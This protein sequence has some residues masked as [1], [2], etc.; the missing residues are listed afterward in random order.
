MMAVNSLHPTTTL[1]V[2][3]KIL[4]IL[5]LAPPVHGASMANG[6]LIKSPLINNHFELEIVNL[7]FASSVQELKKFTIRKFFKSLGYAVTILQKMFQFRPDLVHFT[8]STMGF[9]F[10]RDAFYVFII[11]CFRPAI[12]YHL[13]TKGIKKNIRGHFFKKLIY[14]FVFKNTESICLSENLTKDIE[15]VSASTPYIVP[16]GIPVNRLTENGRAEKTGSI[17]Q[18]LYLG[19]YIESKGVLV[20]I[21][22]LSLLKERGQVFNARLVGAPAD[23]TMQMLADKIREKNLSGSVQATGPLYNEMKLEEYRNADLFVFPTFYE[24]EAF[25]LVLLE[26]LQYGLPIISTF[27]GGIPEMITNNETGLL[28]ESRN[29]EMLA[30]KISALL[31]D[32]ALRKEMGHKGYQR[33]QNNYTLA[34]FENNMLKTF[35]NILKIS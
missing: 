32:P 24:N 8:L 31:S 21:D 14:R 17:P 33:F 35:N 34:H 3:K 12:V 29:A 28:V 13:H 18:I 7:Q 1:I 22:A 10:Y 26:A 19:N 4:C 2:K 9:A 11:K 23:L 30:N 15:Q 27:E 20:L 16:Y 6:Y 5:Q 25:P